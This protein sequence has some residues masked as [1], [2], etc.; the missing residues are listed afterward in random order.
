MRSKC[1]LFFIGPVSLLMYFTVLPS[2][3]K[4]DESIEKIYQEVQSNGIKIHPNG[5]LETKPWNQK[6]FAIIDP[7]GTLLTFGQSV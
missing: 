6:E 4:V 3:L 2:S 5:N 1:S 7:N